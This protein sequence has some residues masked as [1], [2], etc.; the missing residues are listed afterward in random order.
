MTDLGAN[1]SLGHA[2]VIGGLQVQP[3]LRAGAEP[4]A[5]A[6]GGVAGDRPSAADDLRQ[7]IGRHLDLSGQFGRRDVQFCQFVG[8]NFTGVDGGA[9]GGLR[10]AGACVQPHNADSGTA[11][12]RSPKGTRSALSYS[13][14]P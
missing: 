10:G 1:D 6:Q 2:N 3:E 14:T 5:E 4:V 7:A 9:H 8:Q 11:A 12:S 13:T